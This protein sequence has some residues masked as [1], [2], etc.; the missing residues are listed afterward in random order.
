MLIPA[1]RQEGLSRA[2]VHAIASR[3]G[4][5]GSFREFDYGIDLSVDAI[6]QK[7][8]RYFESG[9]NLDI[10]TKSSTRATVLLFSI[11]CLH[12]KIRP[13]KSHHP[14]QSALLLHFHDQVLPQTLV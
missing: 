4:L 10:R 5:G 9:F 14:A 8:N 11:R 7:G 3:Y 6:R 13:L 1:H 2:Y 12:P